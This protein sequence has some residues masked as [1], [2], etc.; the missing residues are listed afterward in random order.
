[1]SEEEN[2]EDSRYNGLPENTD[3]EAFRGPQRHTSIVPMGP[4][5]EKHI[6]S[7]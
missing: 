4:V 3:V 5:L 6:F 7:D 2:H 1:M